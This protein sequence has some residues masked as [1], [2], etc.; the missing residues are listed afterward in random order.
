[1]RATR[2]LVRSRIA[3]GA[4]IACALAPQIG[5]SQNDPATMTPRSPQAS[6]DPARPSSEGA[7]HP[8]AVAALAG[9]S[10]NDVKGG[11]RLEERS[12]GVWITGDVLGLKPGM[13]GFHIHEKGDCSAS[14]ASSAGGHLALGVTVHG[15]PTDAQ[16][17][18]GDLGNIDADA[19][20]SATVAVLAKGVTLTGERGI[21]GR[22][23]IIHG[24]TDDLHTQP[25]GGSGAPVACGVIRAQ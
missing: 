10:D 7:P 4:I 15:A 25:S 16:H 12:D 17:H 3:A 24:G 19:D 8:I 23:F 5:C 2:D 9:T 22:A 6:L 11:L 21:V 20:G 18:A 14:D 13:H 1:M